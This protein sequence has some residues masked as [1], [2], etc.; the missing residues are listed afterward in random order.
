AGCFRRR[1]GRSAT[2]EAVACGRGRDLLGASGVSVQRRALVLALAAVTAVGG[3]E[4]I[5]TFDEA[6][7]D[8][9]AADGGATDT[10]A[11]AGTDAT[12]DSGSDA[13]SE[14]GMD[15]PSDGAMDAGA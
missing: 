10:G 4:I 6:R 13:T 3:C 12:V 5:A 2:M 14:V 8:G 15:V 9:S 11:D 7:L 1:P